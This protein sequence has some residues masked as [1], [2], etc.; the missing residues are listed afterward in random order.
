MI[1]KPQSSSIAGRR[2]HNRIAGQF[3]GLLTEMLESPGWRVL[4]LSARRVIDRVC[5]ELRHNGGYQGHGLCVTY[6]DFQKYGIDRH[7]ISPAIRE[8][9]ALGFLI[10]GRQG[11]AGNADFRQATL[12]LTTFLNIIDGEPT[13][14]WRRIRTVDEAKRIA[15]A[16]RSG[17]SPSKNRRPVGI[18]HGELGGK[19][20]TDNAIS[21]AGETP[22]TAVAFS[23]TTSDISGGGRGDRGTAISASKLSG[24][25]R[26]CLGAA[27]RRGGPGR[28]R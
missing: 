26:I 10:I 21:P 1:S 15:A 4:S 24:V 11:R 25:N 12:Y 13:H 7:A 16:A 18:S 28:A 23:P 8:A 6:D 2:R 17:Q 5:I 14:N 9:V 27:H 22:T 19:T 3:T 20:H